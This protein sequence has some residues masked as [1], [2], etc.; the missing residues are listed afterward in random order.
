MTKLFLVGLFLTSLFLTGCGANRD[1]SSASSSSKEGLLVKK[2]HNE[3]KSASEIRDQIVRG[4]WKSV[5][6]E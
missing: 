5:I 1:S 6:L 2:L 4:E 3:G